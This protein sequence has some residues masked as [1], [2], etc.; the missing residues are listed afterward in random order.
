VKSTQ[1]RSHSA[2]DTEQLGFQLASLLPYDAYPTILLEGD[3]AAGKTTFTKGIARALDIERAINSPTYT[4]LKTYYSQDRRHVLY[5]LDL[6]RLHGVGLDYDLEEYMHAEGF[7]VI[8]WPMHL[9]EILP[10][11]V[12][13]VTFD[14]VDDTTRDITITCHGL[15]CSKV[16][17]L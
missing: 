1:Y 8:E 9:K 15:Y 10:K 12:V 5:H 16:T 3:L 7:K 17:K 2:F 14:Y 11:D 4:I 6:Y 13:V